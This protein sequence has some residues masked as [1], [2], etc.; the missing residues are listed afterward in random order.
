MLIIEMNNAVPYQKQDMHAAWKWEL[1]E[2]YAYGPFSINF[3]QRFLA[4]CIFVP[5]SCVFCRQ[6]EET[7]KHLIF[8][9][10]WLVF[11]M[12]LHEDCNKLHF[13]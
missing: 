12:L 7:T 9:F 13:L 10:S 4:T 6:E 5:P 1:L 3:G 8:S 11:Q 2:G